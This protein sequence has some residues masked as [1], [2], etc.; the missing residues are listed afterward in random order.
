[1]SKKVCKGAG[2]TVPGGDRYLYLSYYAQTALPCEHH[3]QLQVPV[4]AGQVILSAE[5]SPG[6]WQ[7]YFT[8][9]SHCWHWAGF[10]QF[11]IYFNCAWPVHRGVTR[12][13]SPDHEGPS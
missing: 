6:P 13:L 2:A 7:I 11:I 5:D 9:S 10:Q 8:K 1:M 3:V 12:Q 4:S